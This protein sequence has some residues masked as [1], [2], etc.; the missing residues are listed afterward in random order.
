MT[1]IVH[2]RGMGV[3]LANQLTEGE[4]AVDV[5]LGK[6]YTLTSGNLVR[7]VGAAG[8]EAG[9]S[10]PANPLAGTLW[11]DTTANALFCWDGTYWFQVS[12]V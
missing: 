4:L 6:V 3:P 12:A 2:K 7:E 1:T 11:F 8:A 10:A 9:S 5:S